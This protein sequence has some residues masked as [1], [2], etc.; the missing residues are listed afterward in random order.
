VPRSVKRDVGTDGA[1]IRTPL[2]TQL[3]RRETRTGKVP[4]ASTGM[5][6]S[7][8]RAKAIFKMK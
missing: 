5:Q 1:F 2:L 3:G 6:G 8:R 7:M 4:M